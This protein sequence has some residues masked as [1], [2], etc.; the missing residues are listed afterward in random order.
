MKFPGVRVA[1]AG[2]A[3]EALDTSKAEACLESLFQ[4]AT[5]SCRTQDPVLQ[6]SH[7]QKANVAW[8]GYIKDKLGDRTVMF[9][10]VVRR[11]ILALLGLRYYFLGNRVI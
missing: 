1:D 10:S 3:Y 8:G 5:H 6:V 9:L 2:Q 7:S 11:C 4:R